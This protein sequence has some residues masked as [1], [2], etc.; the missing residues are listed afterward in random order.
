MEIE[1]SSHFVNAYQKLPISI[2]KKAEQKELVF[3]NDLFN[4]AL[5][6]HKLSGKLKNFYASSI[7]RKYGIVFAFS[8]RQ[9]AVFLDA[10]DH[11]IY[12]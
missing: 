1:Y 4:A 8:H 3:R 10:G 11:D 5:K 7:D 9:K 6:T 2:Q 12:K